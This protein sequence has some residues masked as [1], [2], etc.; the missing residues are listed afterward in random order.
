MKT[1]TAAWLFVFFVFGF[2]AQAQDI[3]GGI[4][5]SNG[6]DAIY[7][8]YQLCQE[9][10]LTADLKGPAITGP[11]A[12]SEDGLVLAWLQGNKFLTWTSQDEKPRPIDNKFPPTFGKIR[13]MTLSPEGVHLAFE[14]TEKNTSFFLVEAGKSQPSRL[15][16]SSIYPKYFTR[17]E[18]YNAITMSYVSP[19]ISWRY[20]N[21]G[22]YPPTFPIR[23]NETVD[24]APGKTHRVGEVT[25]SVLGSISIP[26]I[27]AGLKVT[28]EEAHK[29]FSI[30]RDAHFIAWQKVSTDPLFFALIYK[31]EKGWG[32]IEIRSTEPLSSTNPPTGQ[33]PGVWEI[34]ILLKDCQS[35]AWKPDGSLTYLSEG[36][37][38]SIEQRYIAMGIENSG[39]KKYREPGN[40]IPQLV[41]VNNVIKVTPELVAEGIDG[42]R[43]HWATNDTFRFRG[44][45]GSRR[46]ITSWHKGEMKK[47]CAAPEEFSYC[48]RAPFSTVKP[49]NIAGTVSGKDKSAKGG[50]STQKGNYLLSVGNTSI[51]WESRPD[52]YF[53]IWGGGKGDHY[54]LPPES[55]IDDVYDPSKYDFKKMPDR[56]TTGTPRFVDIKPN[57]ILLLK[58]NNKYTAIKPLEDKDGGQATQMTYEWKF[59][60]AP[61]IIS[62]R[63][64]SPTES[65]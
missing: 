60:A 28:I 47:L 26:N 23:T 62:A 10:N 46:N 37:V 58:S 52:G 54:A 6:K 43:L 34:P 20:G 53:R 15:G 40:S 25:E 36:K 29:K 7:L 5:S 41:P 9:R 63:T 65:K 31:T 56:Y 27:R 4:V 61:P 39:V 8:D 42:D 50:V 1:T 57:Q 3:P 19:Y 13:N 17:M 51:K 24:Y 12:I 21:T 44:R 48:D 59:W 22:F 64:N 38:F 33:K 16:D 18:E 32:P 35:L 45:E 2:S 30:K 11:L 14:S 49:T 55:N